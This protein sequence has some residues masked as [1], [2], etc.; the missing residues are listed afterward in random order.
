[1]K[2]CSICKQIK[3]RNEFYKHHEKHDG[4]QSHC[5]ICSNA[6]SKRY[7]QENRSYCKT[8]DA[9]YKEQ[10]RKDKQEKLIKYLYLHP[11]VDCGETDILVLEFDHI[12]K[13]QYNI[14]TMMSMSFS[15]EEVLKE[16][17]KCE[18]CCCNCHRR[19][20]LKRQQSYRTKFGAKLRLNL[21]KEIRSCL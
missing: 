19:R 21:N 16:I 1:M 5:K 9:A 17:T 8:R 3:P 7:R 11:C 18:V 14:G 6:G 12:N 13:K 20:T 10:Y 15:W 4:L 2:I